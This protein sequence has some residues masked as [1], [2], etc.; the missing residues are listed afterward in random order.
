MDRSSR[1]SLPSPQFPSRWVRARPNGEHFVQTRYPP[2][3]SPCQ[4]SMISQHRHPLLPRP[5]MYSIWAA[6]AQ[7]TINTV[8]RPPVLNSTMVPHNLYLPNILCSVSQTLAEWYHHCFR[9]AFGLINMNDSHF[10]FLEVSLNV[11][12]SLLM[13]MMMMLTS[14][15]TQTCHFHPK[16]K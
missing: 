13:M 2:C 8:Q 1:L 12:L 16:K 6:W 4:T 11:W 7:P 14:Y 3:Y 9:D 15:Q 5:C 10:F